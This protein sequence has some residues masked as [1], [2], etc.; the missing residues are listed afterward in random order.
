[1]RVMGAFLNSVPYTR[2]AFSPKAI[3]IAAGFFIIMSSTRLPTNFTAIA[4]PPIMFALPG[5]VTPLVTPAF[6]ARLS[7]GSYGLNESI[8]LSCGVSGSFF[9]L[10]SGD[11]PIARAES[12]VWQCAS[13][14]PGVTRRPSA[15]IISASSGASTLTPMPAIFPP[16]I[17]ISPLAMSS[18][19]MGRMCAFLMS[20]IGFPPWVNCYV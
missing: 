8:I 7:C 5:V 20:S 18:P 16:S 13:T 19:A 2:L 15:S 9:S 6:M 4:V 14:M 17:S 1:M 12:P 10:W 3:F 11:M